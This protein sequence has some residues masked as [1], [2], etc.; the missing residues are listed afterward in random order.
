[1]PARSRIAVARSRCPECT[2]KGSVTTRGFVNPSRSKMP[3]SSASAPPPTAIS[4]GIVMI[5]AIGPPSAGFAH[6]KTQDAAG[7]FARFEQLAAG[8]CAEM[9]EILCCAGIGREDFEHGAGGERLQRPPRLQD[10][11]R[12]QK[13]GG[14]E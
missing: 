2:R 4:R 7:L 8:R 3:A 9:L 10:W 14:V 1:M 6:P 12:A 11:Q 13:S 5:G